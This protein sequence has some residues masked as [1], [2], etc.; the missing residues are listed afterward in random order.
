MQFSSMS[1]KELEVTA[2]STDHPEILQDIITELIDRVEGMEDRLKAAEADPARN[3]ALARSV[4]A[5]AEWHSSRYE[6]D[7]TTFAMLAKQLW[8]EVYDN[9]RAVTGS[10]PPFSGAD[11]PQLVLFAEGEHG[12][13]A[14][15]GAGQ[16]PLFG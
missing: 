10:Y 4:S 12:G 15:A 7:N 14:P 9:V 8:H 13:V 16:Q 6:G 2:E 3:Y 11:S 1:L 5:F